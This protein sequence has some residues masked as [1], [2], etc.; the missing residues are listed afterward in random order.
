[1]FELKF[2]FSINLLFWR[3]LNAFYRIIS[4]DLLFIISL[5]NYSQ[6]MTN[7]VFCWIKG[8]LLGVNAVVLCLLLFGVYL[9]CVDY[10]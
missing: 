2:H 5:I 4:N 7:I 1:M 3:D 6:N 9:S 10:V 8:A